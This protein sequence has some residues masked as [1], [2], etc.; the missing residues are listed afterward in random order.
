[1]EF[2]QLLADMNAA[3]EV[4]KETLPDAI[5]DEAFASVLPWM[6]AAFDIGFSAGD[7]GGHYDSTK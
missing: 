3:W 1:M 5:T 2:E 6:H 4:Y 7:S